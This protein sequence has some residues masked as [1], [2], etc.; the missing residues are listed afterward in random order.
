MGGYFS[1]GFRGRQGWTL[2]D[3]RLEWGLLFF[4]GR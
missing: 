1:L 2:T 4:R 3:T